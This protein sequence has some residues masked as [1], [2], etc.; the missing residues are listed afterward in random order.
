MYQN[1]FVC[2]VCRVCASTNNKPFSSIR[3]VALHIAGKIKGGKTDHK[4]WAYDNCSQVKT[5]RALKKAKATNGINVLADL[6]LLP[7]KSTVQRF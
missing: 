7:L 6:F 2:P 5:D 3:S 1:Q 4:I